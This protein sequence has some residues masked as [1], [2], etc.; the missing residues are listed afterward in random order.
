MKKFILSLAFLFL[1]LTAFAQSIDDEFVS[2]IQI[3]NAPADSVFV[4]QF[5][6]DNGDEFVVHAR[7]VYYKPRD[8][9]IMSQYDNIL[10]VLDE[11]DH[12]DLKG[13]PV[14]TT[15]KKK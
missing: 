12:F 13:Y 2:D 5:K 7:S 10:E 11:V 6:T 9:I 15:I 8:F 3:I 14:I 1:S 4:I